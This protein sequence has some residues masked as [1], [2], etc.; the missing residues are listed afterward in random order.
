MPLANHWIVSLEMESNPKLLLQNSAKSSVAFDYDSA[1]QLVSSSKNDHSDSFTY[2]NSGNILSKSGNAFTNNGWQVKS[3]KDQAGNT[4]SFEYSIDGNIIKKQTATSTSTMIYDSESRLVVLDDTKFIYDYAGRLL[5]VTSPNGDV[6]QYINIMYEVKIPANSQQQICTSYIVYGS[7]QASYTAILDQKLGNNNW[8]EKDTN[9]YSTK[10]V[11]E[12]KEQIYYFHSDHLG[13]TVAVSDLTGKIIARYEYDA[14]GKVAITGQDVAR[15]KYSGKELFGNLYYFGARFYDPEVKNDAIN[16]IDVNGNAWVPWW[17]WVIDGILI[18]A[19]VA[20][21]IA[22]APA[23]ITA[24]IIVGAAGGALLGAGFSGLTTDA[25]NEI[26]GTTNDDAAWGKQLLLGAV[27][28]ALTGAAGA[29]VD[30]VLKPISLMTFREG[31]KTSTMKTSTFVLRFTS[32]IGVDAVLGAGASFTQQVVTNAWDGKDDILADTL[33]STLIGGAG[34]AFFS[35]VI[36]GGGQVKDAVAKMARKPPGTV[37]QMVPLQAIKSDLPNPQG[38]LASGAKPVIVWYK[39]MPAF[40]P[41]TDIPIPFID[42][43]VTQL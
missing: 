7:R 23:T 20:V 5:K 28:G 31:I 42:D 10:E 40:S 33:Q 41:R 1:G 14:F 35:S 29:G 9:L 17:H 37:V 13:S 21:C 19:G 12:K 4:T 11:S 3:Y 2:D 38:V 30:K 8:K 43:F 27:F 25:I 24:A 15:Y 32:R 18:V 39:D 34:G 22:F 36:G 6:L 16:F 26:T